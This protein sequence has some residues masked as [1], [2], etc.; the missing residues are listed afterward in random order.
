MPATGVVFKDVGT[1]LRRISLHRRQGYGRK[2]E[3]SIFDKL[4]ITCLSTRIIHPWRTLLKQL[5]GNKNGGSLSTDC[6]ALPQ[7]VADGGLEQR[8]IDRELPGG[9]PVQNM[10]ELDDPSQINMASRCI[11]GM[12]EPSYGFRVR[13]MLVDDADCD[14]PQYASICDEEEANSKIV[15]C[16]E[17]R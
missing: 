15:D 1:P 14:D 8:V 17:P 6:A 9:L 3:R 4:G 2:P 10:V 12:K 7:C 11:P 13:V 5:F 16:P